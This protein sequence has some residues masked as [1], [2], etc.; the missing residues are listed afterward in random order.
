MESPQKVRKICHLFMLQSMG[1]DFT[2]FK[3][4]S[5][6]YSNLRCLVSFFLHFYSLLN[7]SIGSHHNIS[8]KV[9]FLL[10]SQQWSLWTETHVDLVFCAQS[11]E[12]VFDCLFSQPHSPRMETL[13]S[14][15]PTKNRARKNEERGE[16]VARVK[17]WQ[18]W[19]HLQ[20]W[21]QNKNCTS[22]L[23]QHNFVAWGRVKCLD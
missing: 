2:A 7:Y 14:L 9:I 15:C 23:W 10:A 3:E 8:L 21:I 13:N 18:N 11:L 20:R 6:Y 17:V 19:W 5:Y 22:K 4:K 16:R 12:P 1:R